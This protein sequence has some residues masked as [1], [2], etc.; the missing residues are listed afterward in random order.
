[1]M[2]KRGKALRGAWPGREAQ[3]GCCAQGGTGSLREARRHPSVVGRAAVRDKEQNEGPSRPPEGS[4]LYPLA[5]RE[6]F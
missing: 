5:T 2:K 1:M 3:R 4:P 6:G